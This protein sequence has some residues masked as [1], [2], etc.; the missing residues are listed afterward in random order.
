MKKKILSDVVIT[1]D[2]PRGY[3]RK[4]LEDQ[5]EYYESWV[6]EF[7]AFMRDHRSQ[8]PVYLNVERQYKDVCEFC[9]NEWEVDGTGCPCCCNKAQEEWKKQRDATAQKQEVKIA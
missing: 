2:P 1:C 7:T 3:W 4:T 5:A 8:D 9:E 6:K